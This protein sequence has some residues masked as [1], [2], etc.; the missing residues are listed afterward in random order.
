MKTKKISQYFQNNPIRSQFNSVVRDFRSSKRKPK[1]RKSQKTGISTRIKEFL[2]IASF[3]KSKI[4]LITLAI[5]IVIFLVYN[6][7]LYINIKLEKFPGDSTA[8]NKIL[9]PGK[10]STF[11]YHVDTKQDAGITYKYVNSVAL[12][13]IHENKIDY[14]Q[15][16]PYFQITT[17][18]NIVAYLNQSRKDNGE[19]DIQSLNSVLENTFGL[20]TSRYLVLDTNKFADLLVDLDFDYFFEDDYG[21]GYQSDFRIEEKDQFLKYFFDTQ[22]L[23]QNKITENQQRFLLNFYGKKFGILNKYKLMTNFEDLEGLLYSNMS[24][25]EFLTL[26]NSLGGNKSVLSD[27]LSVDEGIINDKNLL[28]PNLVVVDEKVQ[29]TLRDVGVL[30]EQAEIEIYN[31]SGRGGLALNRTRQFQNIGINVV[32]YGNYP[33]FQEENLLHIVEEGSIDRFNRTID[34]IR[35]VIGD[36]DLEIIVGEYNENRSGDL[37][38]ILGQ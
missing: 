8:T 35:T 27:N 2:S 29:E 3:I 11:I 36:S 28:T 31:A 18:S 33:V 14:L 22:Q 34:A 21:Q 17:E 10:F 38:L 5:F 6:Y 26:I 7:D 4:F 30:A 23:P 37:I 25:S 12:I 13:S 19:F 24:R 9:N 32:K 1:G 15:I 16:N 20:S